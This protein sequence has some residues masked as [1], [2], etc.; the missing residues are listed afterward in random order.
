M[1]AQGI[2]YFHA[3]IK[4]SILKNK[5]KLLNFQS[6]DNFDLKKENSEIKCFYQ[7][8][9]EAND[10]RIFRAN[11]E[12]RTSYLDALRSSQQCG[13]PNDTQFR[14][15]GKRLLYKMRLGIFTNDLKKKISANNMKFTIIELHRNTK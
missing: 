15:L 14:K 10:L 1:D 4:I 6:S 13:E 12:P 3:K 2:K 9:K 5:K 7:H 8:L 11:D